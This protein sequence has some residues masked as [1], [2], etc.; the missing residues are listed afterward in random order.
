MGLIMLSSVHDGP[1][2]QT[3]FSDLLIIKGLKFWNR[4]NI[5]IILLTGEYIVNCKSKQW[6]RTDAGVN[7]LSRGYKTFFMLNSD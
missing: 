5:L 6:Q 2:S 3:Y 1:P 4:E 7:I